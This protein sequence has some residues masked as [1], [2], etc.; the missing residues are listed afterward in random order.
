MQDKY[1]KFEDKCVLGYCCLIK[2]TE[3]S[4]Y[5]GGN[6]SSS[7]QYSSYLLWNRKFSY[8]AHKTAKFKTA[9]S[10]KVESEGSTSSTPK[11][12]ILYNSEPVL[13]THP[14]NHKPFL[15][16]YISV[17]FVPS[18]SVSFQSTLST[19]EGRSKFFYIYFLTYSSLFLQTTIATKH[20]LQQ[21]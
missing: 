3:Y 11:P 16:R 8:S 7:S 5:C 13:I 17:L 1:C 4:S 14:Q 6:S 12:A 21:T 18:Y 19:Q 20:Y 15:L 2:S 9:K 10:L